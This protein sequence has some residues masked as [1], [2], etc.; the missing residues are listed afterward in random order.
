MLEPCMS[1]SSTMKVEAKY[2]FEM[3]LGLQRTAGLY[4]PEDKLLLSS[5]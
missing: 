5:L 3:S 2:T 1:Y 4:S